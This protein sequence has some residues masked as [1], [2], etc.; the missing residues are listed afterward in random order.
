VVG[1]PTFPFAEFRMTPPNV[2]GFV[3][4][5]DNATLEFALVLTTG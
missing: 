3:S 1:A 5:D 4:V 2:G